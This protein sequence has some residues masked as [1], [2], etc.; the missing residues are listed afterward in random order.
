M[1]TIQILGLL[2]V[3]ELIFKR[4][5]FKGLTFIL[6]IGYGLYKLMIIDYWG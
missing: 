1:N 5:K 6:W 3:L 2:T 4:E